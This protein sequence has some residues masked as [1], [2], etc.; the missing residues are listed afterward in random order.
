ML[1]IGGGDG[2]ASSNWPPQD[3]FL[4]LVDA[5]FSALLLSR[6]ARFYTGAKVVAAHGLRNLDEWLERHRRILSD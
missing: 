6:H 5:Q 1:A 2:T 4:R 3:L